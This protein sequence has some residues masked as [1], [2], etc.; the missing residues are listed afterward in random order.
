MTR[1][2]EMGASLRPYLSYRAGL[3][4]SRTPVV[5]PPPNV[6]VILQPDAPPRQA[7]RPAVD[8]GPMMGLRAVAVRPRS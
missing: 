3:Q 1:G 7:A 8:W 2:W 4:V 6:F 5:S